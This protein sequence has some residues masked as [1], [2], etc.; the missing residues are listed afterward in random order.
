MLGNENETNQKL[1]Q[2]HGPMHQTTDVHGAGKWDYLM[3]S[4]QSS[5]NLNTINS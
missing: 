1:P 3:L 5:H 2:R 4:I